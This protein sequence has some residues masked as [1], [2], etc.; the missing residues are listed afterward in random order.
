MK[1]VFIDTNLFIRYL[2][3]DNLEMAEQVEQLF[4]KAASGDLRLVTGPPVF[5]EL[6]WT[7]KSF[8]KKDREYIY[9]CLKSILGIEGLETL[10]V[11]ILEP[12]LEIFN[13]AAIDFADAYI[14]ALAKSVQADSIATFN[15]KHFKNLDIALYNFKN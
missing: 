9:E 7:L 10:D 6:A 2:V 14:A 4:D 15:Q 13:H 8:Y 12:A 1:K 11:D 5:F 3:N